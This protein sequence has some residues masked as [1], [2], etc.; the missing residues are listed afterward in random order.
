ME[1]RRKIGCGSQIYR[2]NLSLKNI[3]I[4]KPMDKKPKNTNVNEVDVDAGTLLLWISAIIL[5]PLLIT[6]FLSH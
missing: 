5:I 2:A 1:K 4:V 3:L 6:G